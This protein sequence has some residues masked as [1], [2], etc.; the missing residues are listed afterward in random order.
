MNQDVNLRHAWSLKAPIHLQDPQFQL[1]INKKANIR[2]KKK[3]FE[4]QILVIFLP[5]D[6]FQT[7]GHLIRKAG[8]F[9]ATNVLFNIDL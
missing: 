7:N 9:M 2:V 8:N 5:R 6:K 1:K 3:N 4:R